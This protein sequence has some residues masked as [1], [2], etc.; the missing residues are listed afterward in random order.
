[1]NSG[2]PRCRCVASPIASQSTSSGPYDAFA[3]TTWNAGR[4]PS[5]R[6]GRTLAD[7][8][9]SSRR[10]SAVALKQREQHVA[11]RVGADRAGA[12]DVRAELRQHERRAA[13]RAR[14]R[15]LDLLHQLAALALRD[16]LDGAHEHI[17]HVHPHGN[18]L[19][20]ASFLP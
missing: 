14:G 16:R 8:W 10:S 4:E 5:G 15:H 19:H 17:E 3:P 20:R 12:A 18:G 13:G 1:M 9:T 2:P 7:V 6:I 11:G